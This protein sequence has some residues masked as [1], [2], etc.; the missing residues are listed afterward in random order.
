MNKRSFGLGRRRTAMGNSRRWRAL[1]LLVIL[2]M[3]CAQIGSAQTSATPGE[4]FRQRMAKLEAECKRNPPSDPRNTRCDPLKITPEDWLATPDG[5]FAH[6]IKIPNPVPADSGYQKGMTPQEYFEHLCKNEAGEFIFKTVDNVEGIR[7]LR[8][9]EP[10]NDYVF[11]DLYAMEDSYGHLQE[12]AEEPGFQFLGTRKYT[13][14]ETPLRKTRRHPAYKTLR[15]PSFYA[16]PAPGQ[17]VERYHY[18]GPSRDP[19][20][21]ELQYDTT[22]K[23]RYGITWRGIKR[24]SD[25]EMGIAGGEL[26]VLDLETNEVLGVRRGYAL[27]RGSWEITPLCPHYGYFGGFDKT[28]GFS[29]WFSMKVARPPR[30]KEWFEDNET[31]RRIRGDQVGPVIK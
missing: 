28:T 27:Y 15:H 5:R 31:T 6:S 30:W 16:D 12:E 20:N 18:A 21:L 9:R 11:Q 17:A 25:R 14:L 24:P 22:S 23:A 19:R 1:G 8:P 10:A 13:Y 2:V 7:L 3:G 26:I 29:S 4:Q